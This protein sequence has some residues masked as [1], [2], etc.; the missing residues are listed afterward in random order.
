MKLLVAYGADPNIP[1]VAPSVP[2]RRGGGPPA[3]AGGPIASTAAADQAKFNALPVP[4]GGPGALPST[5]PPASST[6]K[7]SPA[8]LIVMRRTPGWR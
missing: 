6:A 2:V 5:P 1:T 3:G 7:V 4:A 8:T